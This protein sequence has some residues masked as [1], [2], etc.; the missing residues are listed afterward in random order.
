MPVL[1]HGVKA[2]AAPE[3]CRPCRVVTVLH[4]CYSAIEQSSP[5]QRDMQI[6]MESSV[7]PGGPL[8]SG[9]C[10][11]SPGMLVVLVTL[12]GSAVTSSVCL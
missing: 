4:S 10:S 6:R 9:G 3:Q 12:H 7:Q 8:V 11:E 1:F 5:P 2:G